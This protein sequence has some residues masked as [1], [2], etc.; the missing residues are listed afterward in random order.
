[1]WLSLSAAA[2][3]GEMGEIASRNFA[4]VKTKMTP[5]QITEAQRLAREWKHKP[6]K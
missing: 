2:L 1:M 5:K 3:A 4:L 6:A